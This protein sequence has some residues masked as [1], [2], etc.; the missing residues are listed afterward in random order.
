MKQ[1]L[2]QKTRGQAQK[3]AFFSALGAVSL[4][5]PDNKKNRLKE[6]GGILVNSPFKEVGT[7]K[8]SFTSGPTATPDL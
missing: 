1:E 6:E 3:T 2:L 8:V 7:E 4:P 5:P